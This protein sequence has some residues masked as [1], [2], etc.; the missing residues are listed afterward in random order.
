VIRNQLIENSERKLVE[1]FLKTK[2]EQVF[3]E[4][5]RR[6]A[7]ALYLLA[8][9]LVG[10]SETEAEDAVQE[11]W[12][13]ACR[14]LSGFEW[15]SSLRT[16]LSGILVNH[17]RELCRK[18]SSRNEEELTDA[19]EHAAAIKS[20][21]YGLDLERIISNLPAGY[22]H[23]LVLH[24]IEGCTHEEIARLLEISVGTSKSQLFH[25]RK[26]VRASFYS[27]SKERR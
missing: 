20:S 7:P 10:G 3:R 23:V 9:R 4:I 27:E 22:R 15:K 24:D 26:R 13:R 25:A 18:R 1:E 8:L 11:T 6:H 21:N 17:V 12:I 2:D 5:Y 16:W 19:L 14:K